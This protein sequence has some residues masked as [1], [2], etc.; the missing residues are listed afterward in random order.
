MKCPNCHSTPHTPKQQLY[1][2][3]LL[4]ACA[5]L[6]LQQCSA[7]AAG[8]TDVTLSD[9]RVVFQTN[10]GDIEFAFLPHVSEQCN[11]LAS[12]DICLELQ[13]RMLCSMLLH[14]SQTRQGF[15]GRVDP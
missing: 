1:Q 9:E 7:A 4:L 2:F 13:Q 11:L 15:I 12:S 10:W 3:A 14:V 5:N 6:L 8:A